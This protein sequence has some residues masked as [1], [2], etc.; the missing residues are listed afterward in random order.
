MTSRDLADS[1]GQE[2]VP[3]SH[4]FFARVGPAW[5]GGL[6]L[7]FFVFLCGVCL[8]RDIDD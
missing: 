1:T 8:R 4:G 3:T 6:A 7:L 2:T 5:L